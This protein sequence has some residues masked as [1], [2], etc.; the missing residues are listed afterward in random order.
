LSEFLTEGAIWLR[1]Q[2][3]L[4]LPLLLTLWIAWGDIKT[5]RIP[6]YLT[7][8]TALTGLA[9]QLAFHGWSGLLHGL[10]GMVLGFAFL[11][12]PYVWGGMGAG[13]V[14]ALAALGAWLGPG[15][16]L[17]LCCYMGMAGGLLALGVLW[18]KGLLWIKIRQAWTF[19][20][21]W[22]LNRPLGGNATPVITAK[23]GGIPYG[24]AIFLGMALLLG[25][26]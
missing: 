4:V 9:Y 24:V 18:W 6:N 26:G 1:T 20:L 23:T 16:T 15:R 19:L 17:F 7:L 14:K 25:I 2:G 5:N 12:F 21:N 10:L 22:I 8:G 3:D 13:D 11:I